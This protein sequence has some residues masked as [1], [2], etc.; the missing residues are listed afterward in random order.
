MKNPSKGPL[1]GHVVVEVGHSVAAPYAG[2]LLAQ[3]GA[4][5]IKIEHP[6]GGDAARGWGPPFKEDKGPHFRAFNASKLS[7]S[8][9]LSRPEERDAVK[10]LILDRADVVICNLRAGSADKLGLGMQAL[11]A[12]KPE[13][14]YCELGAYGRGGPLSHRPGYDPLMQA[15][16]GVMSVTA[17]SAERPPI[18]VGVSMIDMGAGMWSVIGIL[19]K[20][21]EKKDSG[22]GGSVETS[23]FETAVAWMATPIARYGMGGGQQQPQGSGAAGIVPYQAFKTRNGHLVIA[24]GNDRLFAALCEAMGR[25]DLA[26]DPRFATNGDRVVNREVLIPII[27]EFAARYDNDTLARLLDN[28]RIP[29]APVRLVHEVIKD[30]HTLSLGILNEPEGEVTVGL[31]IRFD[32][33]RPKRFQEAPVLGRDTDTVLKPYL[34]S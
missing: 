2:L 6:D 11:L 22:Q 10:A 20:L 29:N 26:T 14:I 3:L 24:A 31:P 25:V 28:A 5:V 1:S 12:E 34:K 32:G 33:D 9:D 16:C 21:L 27:E 7:V 19:A 17:E 30:P 13:L 18:R 15:F 4:E 8:A 23:L